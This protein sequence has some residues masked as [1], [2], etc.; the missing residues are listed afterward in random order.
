MLDGE[1]VETEVHLQR[2]GRN[3]KLKNMIY[4]EMGLFRLV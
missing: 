2:G 3:I 1:H 4:V